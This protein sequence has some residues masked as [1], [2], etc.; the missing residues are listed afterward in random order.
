MDQPP[1]H[2]QALEDAAVLFA[3]RGDL[4]AARAAYVEATRIYTDLGAN[5]DLLRAD[6]RLRP[7]GM[8]RLRA[9]S[10]TTATGWDALTPTELEVARLVADGHANADIA[11]MLFSSKRT[12]EVHVSRILAKLGVRSRVEIAIEAT[13]HPRSGQSGPL[14]QKDRYCG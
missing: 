2:A 10:R 9:R 4:G 14:P 8:R 3:R 5:W 6:A 13:R 1:R 12:I 7:H 11:A